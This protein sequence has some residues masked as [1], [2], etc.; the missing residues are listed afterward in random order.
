MQSD[1]ESY[2]TIDEILADVAVA[3]G[4]PKFRLVNKGF[5][6]R[7]VK[8]ALRKL[9]YITHFKWS[10]GDYDLP[11]NLML[12]LPSKSFNLIDVFIYHPPTANEPCD[13]TAVNDCCG[14]TDPV[15]VYWKAGMATRGQ[16]T[17]MTARVMPNTQDP[18]Y[19]KFSENQN[20]FYFNT[21]NGMIHFSESC[22]G[23]E[24][25]RL[26]FNGDVCDIVGAKMI[27]PT[28][29]E[30]MILYCTAR[31]FFYLAGYTRDPSYLTLWKAAK[32]EAD[33]PW[34]DSIYY[35]KR[36][37]TKERNDLFIYLNRQPY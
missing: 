32:V 13:S 12:P 18:F 9:N 24:R 1:I 36:M 25:V 5:Y 10:F 35:C 29:R 23:Y 27:P 14:V 37:S 22:A 16:G 6:T 2:L 28:V 21:Q 34:K 4:D 15:R 31:A 8:E 20:L 26:Y 33:G 11:A 19:R 30:G 3:I 17:G 7:I